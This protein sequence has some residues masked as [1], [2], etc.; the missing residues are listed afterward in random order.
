[1]K[2]V[3]I[4]GLA[5]AIPRRSRVGLLVFNH[6]FFIGKSDRRGV[7]IKILS[8]SLRNRFV[9]LRLT[10]PGSAAMV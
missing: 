7:E 2:F 8:R 1:M 4:S 5:T 6:A 10:L 3:H 9:W